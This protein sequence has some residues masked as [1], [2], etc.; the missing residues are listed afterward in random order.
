MSLE[1]ARRRA[2]VTGIGV[3]APTG[4]GIEAWWQA[5]LAGDN[6]I[7]P[8]SRFD[9][10]D[11]AVRCAGAVPD[12]EPGRWLDERL[13]QQTDRGTQMALVA[14]ALALQDAGLDPEGWSPERVGIALAGAPGHEWGQRQLQNLWTKGPAF[15]DAYTAIAWFPGAAAGQISVQ[16]G[17]RG[18]SQ[19]TG[20]AETGG[21]EVLDDARW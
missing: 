8:I 18:T 9:T 19:V 20:T 17:I 21:L 2:V 5:S 4:T 16:F 7:E 10:S 11:Y 6:G 15:V 14:T 13:L 3:I 12:F 1:H